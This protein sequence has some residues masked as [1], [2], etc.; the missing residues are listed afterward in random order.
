MK[1][2]SSAQSLTALL[3]LFVVAITASCKKSS[4]SPPTLGVS[5]NSLSMA[6]LS[7]SKDTFNITS[8]GSWTITSNQTWLTVN[9][10]SGQGNATIIATGT[11]NAGD[12]TTRNAKIAVIVTGGTNDT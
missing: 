1:S 11:G 12:S 8:S 4:S 2:I 7:N 6:A 3:M 5:T 10:A 9:Q